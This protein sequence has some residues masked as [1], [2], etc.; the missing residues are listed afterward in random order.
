MLPKEIILTGGDVDGAPPLQR[1]ARSQWN[2]RANLMKRLITALSACLVAPSPGFCG[3]SEED[4]K[5]FDRF[6]THDFKT[7]ECDD[8]NKGPYQYSYRNI[9]TGDISGYIQP[10]K[11]EE[12]ATG[13]FHTTLVVNLKSLD[14]YAV[15]LTFFSDTYRDPK[16][17]VARWQPSLHSFR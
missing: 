16:S 8:D 11:L 14:A 3:Q 10:A 7:T 17:R 13:R 2:W 5:R 6:A 1:P 15:E 9:E 4:L 12:D